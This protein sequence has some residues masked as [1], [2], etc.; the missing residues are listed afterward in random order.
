ME[1]VLYPHPVLRWKSSP[2]TR[3]TPQLKRWVKEMFDLMYAAKGI[4]LAANQVGLPFRFFVMNPTGDPAEKN[5]EL[6]LINPE[7]TIP[8]DPEP[9]E[10][11]EGCLSLPEVFGPVM[12]PQ[13]VIVEAYDLTGRSVQYRLLELAARVAQHETDHLDG[14]LF[15]DRMIE[16]QR[17]LLRPKLAE[18][19][20]RFRQR[21]EAG[22]I[23]SDEEIRRRLESMVAEMAHS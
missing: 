7:I 18:F 5:E 9:Q 17:K 15:F 20:E 14:I 4:G 22:E 3:I 19:E 6:V 23:E 10:G 11:E 21:R 1:I 13:H 2:V 12:R 8:S 16:E